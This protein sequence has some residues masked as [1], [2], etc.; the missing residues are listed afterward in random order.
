MNHYVIVALILI[1]AVILFRVEP[2]AQLHGKTVAS[3]EKYAPFC[4]LRLTSQEYGFPNV[5]NLSR[6]WK[7]M[8]AAWRR[9][10]S[11]K[12]Y[13]LDV[14]KVRSDREGSIA[15]GRTRA[16]GL[17]PLYYHD[18]GNFAKR[19][20]GESFYPE[21]SVPYQEPVDNA[22]SAN[23]RTIEGLRYNGIALYDMLPV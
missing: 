10:Y 21:T 18:P 19:F 1:V 3:A 11:R 5:S 17:N 14:Q 8:P 15:E 23:N 7:N 4:N 2:F 12:R 22:S 16:R 6:Y 9:Q 20:P 13:A